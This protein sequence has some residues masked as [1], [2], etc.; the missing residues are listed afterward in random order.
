MVNIFVFTS[1]LKTEFLVLEKTLSL[2]I[3]TSVISLYEKYPFH[4]F[5]CEKENSVTLKTK[6]KVFFSFV[7]DYCFLLVK[8]N[9]Q[10]II[11][12]STNFGDAHFIN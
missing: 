7:G 10:I 11:V 12:I 1:L 4:N 6:K 9:S 8:C 5:C 2:L 3:Q